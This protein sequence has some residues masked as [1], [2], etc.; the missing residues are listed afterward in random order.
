MKIETKK[1]VYISM[2]V[3]QAMILSYIETMLPAIPIQGA[4][5]GLANIATVLALSTLNFRSC[6][7]IVVAR[8]LLTGLLFG[9][10]ASIIYSITGGLLSLL[11]MYIIMKLFGNT[12]SLVSVSI[13][14]SIF[15]NLGQLGI[16]VLILENT[17][18]L[19]LLPY[20]FLIAIPTGLF[21]G[22]VSKYLLS[23][24]S[25]NHFNYKN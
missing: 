6:L 18:L 2:L 3:T 22:I 8:T 11:A 1:L 10:M 20:L 16:A 25:K 12:L 7:F 17:R 21:V 5:L 24:L 14:G 4:K 23:Y 15:H 9:N 19:I 13:V